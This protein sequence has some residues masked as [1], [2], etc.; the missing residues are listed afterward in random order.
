MEQ[1]DRY[2]IIWQTTVYL[3]G[4]VCPRH[5]GRFYLFSLDI[6][7]AAHTRVILKLY[8]SV[9]TNHPSPSKKRKSS[10]KARPLSNT[11]NPRLNGNRAPPGNHRPRNFDSALG[12]KSSSTRRDISSWRRRRQNNRRI[13][14]RSGRRRRRSSIKSNIW[15]S[16]RILWIYWK[17]IFSQWC[18]A[19]T[20][21]LSDPPGVGRFSGAYGSNRIDVAVAVARPNISPREARGFQPAVGVTAGRHHYIVA[22]DPRYQWLG[23]WCRCR[24]RRW[25]MRHT[26]RSFGPLGRPRLLPFP[27]EPQSCGSVTGFSN[28]NCVLSRFDSV[29]IRL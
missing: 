5:P 19:S 25:W 8:P 27:Q 17:T 29:A 21:E 24:L 6:F 4:G 20:K 15:I 28:G 16:L 2:R 10:K 13:R 11:C 18:R 23:S 26:Y 1:K 22:L 7:T 9:A 12:R 3:Q 14:N